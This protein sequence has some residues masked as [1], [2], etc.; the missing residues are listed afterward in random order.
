MVRRG[1]TECQRAEGFKE[2]GVLRGEDGKRQNLKTPEWVHF[3]GLLE[4]KLAKTL[5]CLIK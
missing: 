2:R 1:W 3:C 5:N 4:N